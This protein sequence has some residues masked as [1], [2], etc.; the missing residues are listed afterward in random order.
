ML[1][2]ILDNT[3]EYGAAHI[4]TPKDPWVDAT[5]SEMYGFLAIIIYMGFVKCCSFTDYWRKAELYI[6]PFPKKVIS[7]KTF[8]RICR[9]LHLSSRAEDAANDEKKGTGSYDRLCKIK[10]L[11]DAMRIAYRTNY[12]PTQEIYIDERIVASKFRIGLKQYLKSKPVKW[13]SKLFVLAGSSNT[14]TWDFFVYEGKSQESTGKGLSYNSVMQLV[15]TSLL[16]TGYKLF[17]DYFYTLS[18]N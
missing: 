4:G 11:S 6:L 10:P 14:Y 18:K 8:L 1:H 15:I 5:Q 7:G 13:G 12:H 3:N 9:A 2:T 16:G 17:V